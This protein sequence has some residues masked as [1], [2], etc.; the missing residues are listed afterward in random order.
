MR[1]RTFMKGGAAAALG[2]LAASQARAEA[3][4]RREYRAGIKLSVIGLGGIV[5]VGMDQKEADRTVA[6]AFD[7]GV[8][9]FD[10]APSYYDGEAETKLGAAL[11]S[12]RDRVFLACKTLSRDAAGARKELEQ[13]LRRLKTG[14][15][16][17]YQFHAVSSMDDVE[18][19]LAPGGAAETFLKARDEGKIRY[20]GASAHSAPAAISLMDRF[21]LDSILFPVNFVLYQEGKFGPQILEHAKSKGVARLALKSLAYTEWQVGKLKSWSKCW[22]QPID[23]PALAE[24]A[25][26]FTLSEDVTAAIPPGEEKLFR[27]ALDAASR[28][29]PLDPEERAELLRSTAGVAPIFKA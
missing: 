22:Y 19:I 16:D 27:M 3:L 25:V 2:A 18:K 7:R 23:R 24:M 5:V 17:L 26:R 13:S 6:E 4:P 1:R 15:F 9:Y 12:R 11:A 10:V 29:R 21:S 8:N 14:R 28:F 20:L